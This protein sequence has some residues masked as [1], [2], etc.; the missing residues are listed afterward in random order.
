MGIR[1][2]NGGG[3]E[4]VRAAKRKSLL[5]NELPG[6][7]EFMESPRKTEVQVNEIINGTAEDKF[8]D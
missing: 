4:A 2:L 1:A 8:D 6:V 5:G 7:D 3:P